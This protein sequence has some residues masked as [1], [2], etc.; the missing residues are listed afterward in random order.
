MNAS[1]LSSRPRQQGMV[2][3]VAVILLITVVIF[4]LSQSRSITG[5]NSTDNT[6]QLASNAALFLAESGLETANGN[7]A[8][9]SNTSDTCAGPTS[10]IS[11]KSYQIGANKVDLLGVSSPATCGAT[12]QPPCVSCTVTS[13]GTV[14]GSA[15]RKI[16]RTFGLTAVNGTSCN[17]VTQ[18]DCT[19]STSPPVWKLTLKNTY[20]SNAVALFNMAGKRQGNNVSA[21]CPVGAGCQLIWNMDSQNG[22]KSVGSMG[23]AVP[24]AAGATHTIYQ[25]MSS[26]FNVAEVGALFPGSSAPSIVGSNLGYSWVDLGYW[27]QNVNG[28]ASGSGLG[29]TKDLGTGGG[30]GPSGKGTIPS[31]GGVLNGTLTYSVPSTS[32]IDPS[33]VYGTNN[34]FQPNSCTNWCYGGD[35]LAM[36]FSASSSITTCCDALNDD[37]TNNVHGVLF[38]TQSQTT[39]NA[40]SLALT[41]IANFPNAGISGAPTDTFSEIWYAH[42]PNLVVSA[43]NLVQDQNY[44]IATVGDTDFMVIGASASTVGIEFVRNVTAGTG[45]GTATPGTPLLVNAGFFVVGSIYEINLPG[46]TVWTG[47]G[48]ANSTARSRFIATGVGSGTGNAFLLGALAPRASSYKG[49]GTGAIGATFTAS[50]S[51]NTLTVTGFSG[52]AYPLQIISPGVVGTGDVLGGAGVTAGTIDQQLT[53]NEPLGVWGGRGTYRTTSSQDLASQAMTATSYTLNVSACTICVFAAGNPV[54]GLIANKTISSQ[55]ALDAVKFPGESTG[56]VGRYILSSSGNPVLP[57]SAS[58]S[59]TLRAGS[60]GTT[61]YLP[62]TSAMP[63]SGAIVTTIPSTQVN[64]SGPGYFSNGSALVS[65]LAAPSTG[66]TPPNSATNSFQVPTA[67]TTALDLATICAGTC[68]LFDQRAGN[69]TLYMIDKSLTTDYWASGFMCLRGADITPIPVTSSTVQYNLWTEVV[70]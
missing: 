67:P 51:S 57:T 20:S 38:N 18:I 56:G 39:A 37:A 47:I 54:S 28:Q 14:V 55:L 23:N 26:N 42:N 48:A 31:Y 44:R 52:V 45:T 1:R 7:F 53:S 64:G 49:N 3:T 4:W 6:N 12:G 24:I 58:S 19:N 50:R 41:R 46:S 70:Q 13:T 43:P 69:D 9:G 68:A 16:A 10:G 33:T 32:C 66:I 15:S 61:I 35:T 65:N 2:V 17:T 21:S 62:S 29:G 11:K 8:T 36:G 22:A 5:S 40:A 30:P 63:P 25:T 27:Y 34:N 59:N 60:V